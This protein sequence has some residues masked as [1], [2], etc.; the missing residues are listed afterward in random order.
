[1][2]APKLYLN[3][4]TGSDAFLALASAFPGRVTDCPAGTTIQCRRATS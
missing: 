4:C 3:H 1:M 2:G